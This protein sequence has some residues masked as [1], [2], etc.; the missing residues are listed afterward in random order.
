MI[1]FR[2]EILIILAT[3][4]VLMLGVYFF[5]NQQSEEVVFESEGV[6]QVQDEA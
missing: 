5:F 2:D 1:Q 4:A 6:T 3:L